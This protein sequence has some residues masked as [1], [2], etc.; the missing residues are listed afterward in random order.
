MPPSRPLLVGIDVGTT[1]TKAGIVD[2]NGCELGHEATPTIWKTTATGA[3]TTGEDLFAAVVAALTK[4]LA[5]A[6][7]GEIVGVGVTSMAET[8]VLLDASGRVVGPSPAWHDVRASEEFAALRAVFGARELGRRTGLHMR[9]VPTIANLRWLIANVPVTRHAVRALSVAEWIVH[10]LGGDA[11]A[12]ASLASR[13]GALSVA[14]RA[15]WS[16][17]L[18]WAGV[19][20]TIFPA[21]RQAGAPWGRVHGVPTSCDRLIGAVLTVAGHDHLCAS[22]GVGAIDESQVTDDCGTAEALVRAVPAAA[23]RDLGTGVEQAITTGWHVLDGHYALLGGA[24]FGLELVS[25]LDRLG[26]TSDD[27]LTSLDARA[28]ALD[29]TL[30]HPEERRRLLNPGAVIGDD[31]PEQ[32]WWSAVAAT[33]VRSR[34]FVDHLEHLD[35]P[36]SEV[37]VSGGWS[38]NPLLRRLKAATFPNSVYPAVSEAGIRGAAMLAGLAAGYFQDVTEFP[39]VSVHVVAPRR[40]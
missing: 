2:L 17:V 18:D 4:V 27:G 38:R 28:L 33:V 36:V 26:A 19:P 8:A 14:S 21:V 29:E 22:I 25:V 24:P 16:E 6:S 1:L 31:S 30:T 11:A 7:S 37:R 10:A 13:T 20:T 39:P 32:A 9:P 40:D 3:E 5:S 15:W 12:E 23:D 35:G 34:R